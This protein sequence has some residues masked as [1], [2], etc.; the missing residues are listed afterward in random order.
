MLERSK[1]KEKD[2]RQVLRT[3]ILFLTTLCLLFFSKQCTMEQ[4]L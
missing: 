3:V 4:F 1:V 2:A